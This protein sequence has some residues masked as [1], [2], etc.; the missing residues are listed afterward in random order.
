[1]SELIDDVFRRRFDNPL[2][3]TRDDSAVLDGELAFTTDSYVVDPIFFP[4]G[5]IGRLAISGTV[6]DLLCSGAI[7][8]ALSVSFI[9]EEGLPVE[10]L[11][12]IAESMRATACEAQVPIVTG[13][14]KVVP[15]GAADKMF[16]TTTGIGRLR[17]RADGSIYHISG[18]Y[19]EMGDAVIVTGSLG[20]HG[21]AVMSRREGLQFESEIVSDVAPL[22]GLIDQLLESCPDVHVLRD[23]TRGGLASALNEIADQSEVAIEIDEAAIPVNESVR[24]ACELLGIDPLYVANEGKMVVILPSEE[25]DNA[26]QTLRS[27][28][29]GV[30]TAL[31]G[32][33]LH[34]PRG[35][36]TLKTPLGNKRVLA[37]HH[38]E[39]LP[40]IC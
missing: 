17:R 1:M 39:L 15:A 28:E 22:N 16:I 2:L 7:P 6:N 19:A 12:Q 3:N 8:V 35:R 9:L 10:D 40:R 13:D 27:N 38:G 5:D 14:T 21:M 18:R 29:L 32:R 20:D 11:E 34:G 24:T 36:V 30:G 31:I 4:G 37:L 25:I 23:P 26:I 33:V